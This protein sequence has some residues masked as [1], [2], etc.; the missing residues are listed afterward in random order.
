[1]TNSDKAIAP[2]VVFSSWST[3]PTDPLSQKWKSPSDHLGHELIVFAAIEAIMWIE[4]MKL[5]KKKNGEANEIANN[6]KEW[7]SQEL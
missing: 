4:K 1:M 2:Q 7:N 6:Y 3:Y 5:Y